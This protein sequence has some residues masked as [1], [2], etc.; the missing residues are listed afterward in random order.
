MTKFEKDYI[1][2]KYLNEVAEYIKKGYKVRMIAKDS[3]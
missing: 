2:V 1:S 3:L